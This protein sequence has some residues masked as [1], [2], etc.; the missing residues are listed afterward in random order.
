LAGRFSVPTAEIGVLI[1]LGLA[2]ACLIRSLELTDLLTKIT[3]G[4]QVSAAILRALGVHPDEAST[5]ASY[6]AEAGIRT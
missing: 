6:A 5:I 3:L 4:Q 2:N 1:V